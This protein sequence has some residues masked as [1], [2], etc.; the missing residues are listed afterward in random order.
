MC[1]RQGSDQPFA[2]ID[3]ELF[4]VGQRANQLAGIS[5]KQVH[6]GL[7]HHRLLVFGFGDQRREAMSSADGRLVEDVSPHE[8][9]HH[10]QHRGVG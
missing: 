8:V 6:A 1:L 5:A 3:P 9:A 4:I 7:A 2:Q 10:G